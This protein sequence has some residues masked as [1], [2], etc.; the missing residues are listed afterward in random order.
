MM[1]MVPVGR[2]SPSRVEERVP[3]GVV[4]VRSPVVSAVVP[5][6]ERYA[7][8]EAVEVATITVFLVVVLVEVTRDHAITI[9]GIL[10]DLDVV[11]LAFVWPVDDRQLRIAAGQ[12]EDRD[13]QRGQNS[14]KTMWQGRIHHGTCMAV[15]R[16]QSTLL[17]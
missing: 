14:G 3:E 10:F 7:E 15:A 8:V 9:L 17:L 6:T 13:Q 4:P 11:D 12:R 2:P 1:V 5:R 16:W